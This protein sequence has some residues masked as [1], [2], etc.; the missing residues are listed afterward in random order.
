MEAKRF[1]NIYNFIEI[2][3]EIKTISFK[4][5]TPLSTE[6]KNIANFAETEVRKFNITKNNLHA[7]FMYCD[8]VLTEEMFDTIYN[9]RTNTTISSQTYPYMGKLKFKILFYKKCVKICIDFSS[10]KISL[11][12]SILVLWDGL[13]IK[14]YDDQQDIFGRIKNQLENIHEALKK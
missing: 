12:D 7:F 8:A 9:D 14:T 3:D 4:Q 13:Y 5:Q 1:I 6:I 10:N 2:N 11:P